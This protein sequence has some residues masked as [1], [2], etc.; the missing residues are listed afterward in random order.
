M[1]PA[2]YQEI[3]ASPSGRSEVLPYIM[4][5]VQTA[6]YNYTNGHSSFA[7]HFMIEIQYSRQSID[8]EVKG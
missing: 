7:T 4:P 2:R 3:A 1:Y 5:N 6:F 8:S